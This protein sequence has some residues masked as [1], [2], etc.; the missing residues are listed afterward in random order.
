[1]LGPVPAYESYCVSHFNAFFAPLS[2]VLDNLLTLIY[3]AIIFRSRA[4]TGLKKCLWIFA[5]AGTNLILLPVV[6]PIYFVTR[7]L[8]N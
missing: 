6:M 2:V 4:L 8:K 3:G 1:P 5:I 7:T